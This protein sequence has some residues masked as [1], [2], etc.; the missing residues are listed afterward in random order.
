MGCT[1][2]ELEAPD[3]REVLLKDSIY[4]AIGLAAPCLEKQV[5]FNSFL[6]STLIPE[7]QIQQSGYNILRRRIAILLGQWYPIKPQELDGQAVCQVFQHLL[8]KADPVNDQVVRVTAGRQLKNILDTLEFT[9]EGFLPYIRPILTSLVEL[10]EE[11]SLIE[12]KMS[13]LETVRVV[14]V[15]MEDHVRDQ[16]PNMVETLTDRFPLSPIKSCHCYHRCGSSPV[17]NF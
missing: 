6:L 14:V 17:T 15:K 11:M 12:T 1:Q 13:L 16:L 7:V 8:N 2:T 3:N 10:I 4:S 5:D 9:A